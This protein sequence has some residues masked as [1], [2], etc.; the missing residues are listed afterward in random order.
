MQNAH[1][2]WR[3]S[4]FMGWSEEAFRVRLNARAAELGKPLRQLLIEGGLG[5]D[6]VDK[7]PTGSRKVSTLEKIAV[8]VGWTLP[9]VMGFSAPLGLSVELSEKAFAVAERVLERAPIEAQTR[10]TLILLHAR[11]YDALAVRVREGRPA[12]DEILLAYEEMLIG[13]IAQSKAAVRRRPRANPNGTATTAR[14]RRS[15]SSPPTT[16]TDRDC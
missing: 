13:E 6:T 14:W 3:G 5:H 11:L 4:K 2:R 12:D 7:I 15:A 1:Y 8:A 9:E 16:P 10:Q